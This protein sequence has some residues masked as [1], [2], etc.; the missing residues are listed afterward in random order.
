VKPKKFNSCRDAIHD[1]KAVVLFTNLKASFKGI[2]PL[3]IKE[4]I[5]IKV[6]API[7][8]LLVII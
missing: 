2:S 8:C 5:G 4:P 7:I 3:I 6:S 1:P